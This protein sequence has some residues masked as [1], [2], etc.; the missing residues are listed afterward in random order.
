M[1]SSIVVALIGAASALGTA[2]ITGVV[3]LI[4][5]RNEKTAA[6]NRRRTKKIRGAGAGLMDLGKWASGQDIEKEIK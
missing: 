3:V 2:L 5:R 1:D 6:A 4:H